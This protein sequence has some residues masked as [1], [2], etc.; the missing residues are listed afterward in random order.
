VP[1]PTLVL[2]PAAG[3]AIIF[4]GDV[5]HAGQVC[6]G[7]VRCVLV[8]SFSPRTNEHLVAALD[9]KIGAGG[10]AD[11]GTGGSGATSVEGVV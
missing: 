3:S 1:E 6:T 11:G 9:R 8:A 7:G 5:T 4:G 2:R 10:G